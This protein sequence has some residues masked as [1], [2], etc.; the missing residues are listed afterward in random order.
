MRWGLRRPA[1]PTPRAAAT[2]GFVVL[3]GQ[4][5]HLRCVRRNLA[6]R[7]N[8]TLL[9]FRTAL[10]PPRVRQYNSRVEHATQVKSW[11]KN[12]STAARPPSSGLP[13]LPGAFTYGKTLAACSLADRRSAC[14]P[15]F[16]KGGSP[17]CACSPSTIP[18][19][20]RIDVLD[21]R[22]DVCHFVGQRRLG[23]CVEMSRKLAAW[24]NCSSAINLPSTAQDG[25]P[26][27]LS[28]SVAATSARA[29]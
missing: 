3:N 19:S 15:G 20:A 25:S 27:S 8:H 7:V 13:L 22:Q 29:R 18:R 23:A 12:A 14:H 1:P 28:F 11:Q 10:A 17:P 9:L 26:E 2:A 21:E 24:T 4:P 6:E 5:Q 16:R